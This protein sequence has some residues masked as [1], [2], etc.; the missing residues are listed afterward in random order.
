MILV[1]EEVLGM[2][3]KKISNHALFKQALMSMCLLFVFGFSEANE[4][5]ERCDR[6]AGRGVDWDDIEV[7]SALVA[8]KDAVREQPKIARLQSQYGRALHKSGNYEEALKWYRLAAAQGYSGGRNNLALMYY[9]GEGVAQDYREAVKWFRLP[10]T[11][12]EY[13]AFCC[14]HRVSRPR[15]L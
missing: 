6:L 8:C 2:N 1:A 13:G 5:A 14:E 15:G 7:A 3:S 11:P 9:Y 4:I 12:C 10:Q